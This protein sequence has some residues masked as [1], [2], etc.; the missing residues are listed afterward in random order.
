MNV[1]V[2]N[3]ASRR[4][5]EYLFD[6]DAGVMQGTASVTPMNGTNVVLPSMQGTMDVVPMNSTNAVI[7]MQGSMGEFYVS[8][9]SLCDESDVPMQGIPSDYT[10][11]DIEYYTTAYLVGD[12]D[13]M[14][15]LFKRLREK[16]KQAKAGN[17]GAR[18]DRQG[19]RNQRREARQ[20]RRE[21]RNAA[22]DLRRDKSARGE[23]FLDRFGGAL[24]DAASGFAARQRAAAELEAQ[25]IEFD[26]DV[27][28]ERIALASEAGD[29]G[30][31]LDFRSD[32]GGDGQ[33]GFFAQLAAKWN[34]LGTPE[35]VGIGIAAAGLGYLGYKALTKKKGRK[36]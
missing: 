26:D 13:A 17:K 5:D 7:P 10:D 20:Q 14:Q 3:G 33:Q 23:G 19:R 32:T 1:H 22:R 25:G 4:T 8:P 36:R 9:L 34:A 11:D 28:D 15:G 24:K 12:P 21:D 31:D 29:F 16:R 27:L 30:D 2:M 18:L 35:K 6:D